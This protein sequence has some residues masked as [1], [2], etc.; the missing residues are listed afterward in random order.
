M[1]TPP[2]CLADHRDRLR[3]VQRPRQAQPL[4]AVAVIDTPAAV[5]SLRTESL[6]TK[7]S[8]APPRPGYESAGRRS[9]PELPLQPDRRRQQQRQAQLAD[10]TPSIPRTAELPASRQSRPDPHFE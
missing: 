3:Q 9:L 7:I 5:V 6:R 10:L 1:V 4:L 8:P 2:H